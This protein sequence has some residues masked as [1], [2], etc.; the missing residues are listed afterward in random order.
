MAKFLIIYIY[1]KRTFHFLTIT[2]NCLQKRLK[3]GNLTANIVI[4][5]QILSFKEGGEIW[6]ECERRIFE[7]KITS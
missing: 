1:I 3:E 5:Y 6:I 2:K 7:R 4:L